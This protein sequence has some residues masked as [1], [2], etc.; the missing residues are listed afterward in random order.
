MIDMNTDL[1]LL[2][3]IDE[4]FNK[5]SISLVGYDLDD[6]RERYIFDCS[7]DYGATVQKLV[8]DSNELDND[9]W[10]LTLIRFTD[11]ENYEPVFDNAITNYDVI[12]VKSS[13]VMSYL[14]NIS[15]M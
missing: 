2:E 9:L 11:G 8:G 12:K 13:N 10:E 14:N 15:K 1:E 4:L 6:Y 3:Y 7:N 5:G